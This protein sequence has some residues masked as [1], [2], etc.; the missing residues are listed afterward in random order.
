MQFIPCRFQCVD[1]LKFPGRHF[2]EDFEANKA[3]DSNLLPSHQARQPQIKMTSAKE[4]VEA[5]VAATP[6][7]VYSKSTCP[8]CTKAKSLLTQ[9]GAKYDVVE[10]DQISDGREQQD[11]L[12]EITGQSTVPNIFVGGKSIGGNSDLHKL[13]KDGNLELVLKQEGAFAKPKKNKRRR[14]TKDEDESS[15]NRPSTDEDLSVVSTVSNR[16][17]IN[18]FST[19]GMKKAKNVVQKQLI[20]SER[21]IVPQQYAGDATYETQIDTEKDR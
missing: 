18:T 6:M 15:T 7:V 16:R 14:V 9:L 12:E 13:H 19:G 17:S 5:K 1:W 3:L 2:P 4:T 20:E 21:E 10:L 8:Y 11:A